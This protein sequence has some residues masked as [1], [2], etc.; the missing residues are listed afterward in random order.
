MIIFGHEIMNKNK[1][2]NQSEN[3]FENTH[4]SN[5]KKNKQ[6]KN[7]FQKETPVEYKKAFTDRIEARKLFWDEYRKLKEIVDGGFCDKTNKCVINYYGI[8][9]MGKTTLVNKLINELDENEKGV[10]HV[11]LDLENFNN[12]LGLLYSIRNILSENYG[13][14]F[15]KFD[16]ALTTYLKK[17]GKNQ[18]TPEIKTLL[19]TNPLT[20]IAFDTIAGA[21]LSGYFASLCFNKIISWKETASFKSFIKTL[22]LEQ[23]PNNIFLK[24]P[25]YLSEDI[26]KFLTKE[27]YT[28]KEDS[29]IVFF[30]DAFEGL[31]NNTLDSSVAVS[32]LKW[33]YNINKTGLINTII[34][35]MFVITSREE[36][37]YIDKIKSFKIENFD[38][39]YSLEYL[40]SAGIEDE[41]LCNE[42]YDNYAKGMPL[43]LS[44]CVDSYQI[45]AKEVFEENVARSGQEIIERLIGKMDLD[46]QVLIYFLSCLNKWNDEFVL[47]NAPKCIEGFSSYRY[48]RIKRLSF[49]SEDSEKNYTFDKTVHMILHNDNTEFKQD[50]KHVIDKTNNFLVEYYKEKL[51][52]DNTETITERT[53]ALK[54]YIERKILIEADKENLV[55]DF[56]FIKN[57]LKELEKL[58]LFDELLYNLDILIKKYE[59]IT[60]IRNEMKEMQIRILYLSGK[61]QEEE[62]KAKEYISLDPKNINAMEYLSLA[63]MRNSKYDLAYQ[64]IEKAMAMID[65]NSNIREYI[66]ALDKKSEIESRMAKHDEVLKNYQWMLENLDIAYS[67]DELNDKKRKI[68]TN[69]AKTYSYKGENGKAIEKFKKI[70]KIDNENFVEKMEAEKDDL[71]IEELN[72]Y[73]DLGNAYSNHGEL[74]KALELKNELL[75][76]YVSFFGTDHPWCLNVMNDIAMIRSH[77]GEHEEA[78][79][80]LHNVCEKRF[81]ILGRKHLSSMAALNNFAIVK[82]FYLEKMPDDFE[83]KEKDLRLA[84][85]QLNEVYEVRKEVLGEDHPSTLRTEYN[86][87]KTLEVL[88][89]KEVALEMAQKLYEKRKQIFGEDNIGTRLTKEL[90]EK[91]KLKD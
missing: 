34:N 7:K 65:S 22:E 15:N 9:G 10:I 61:Y 21:S 5:G 55:N 8:G 50:M 81:A 84:L 24:L 32:K 19:D 46:S 20:K 47:A 53:M 16:L 78:V 74:D 39:K 88:N 75:N 48:E 2:V 28:G 89:E 18:D 69:I 73:N 58:L 59:N 14:K 76:I 3:E 82:V 71:T 45:G 90:M 70:L 60:E 49:I 62:E 11:F 57:N 4:K 23:L 83:N 17:V 56:N 79:Q 52:K 1:K 42:I 68:D 86:I 54:E 26:N 44:T 64:E 13:V 85:E 91:I 77:M 25:E 43:M 80:L 35:S 72:L 6:N 37:K 87:V 29:K 31:D 36:I 41:K 33:L 30:I 67:G 63:Y 27:E 38:K 12:V 66:E 40:K 51:E